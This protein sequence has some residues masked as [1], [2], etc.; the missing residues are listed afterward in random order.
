MIRKLR[1][2]QFKDIAWIGLFLAVMCGFMFW[3]MGPGLVDLILG[4]KPLTAEDRLEDLEGTYVSWEA[5]CPLEEYMETTKTTKVNGVSTGTKKHRSSWVVFDENRGICIS[6]EVPAKREDEMMLR[7]DQFYKAMEE[8]E[9]LPMGGVPV[10]GTLEKLE[11]EELRYFEYAMREMG[12][13]EET[14]VYQIRDGVVHG[15]PK[16]NIYGISAISGFLLLI[17]LFI[18]FKTFKNSAGKLIK[19]YLAAH[20]EVSMEQLESDFEAAKAMHGVW[21]GRNWTF[22]AKLEK[23]LLDNRQAIWVHTGSVRQGRGVNFYVW[24]EMLDGSQ[25]QVS[26]SSEKKCTEIM[27]S[28]GSF[29]H[30][31]VGNNPEYGYLLRNDREAFLGMKYRGS[32]EG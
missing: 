8:G 30:M 28:Y 12:F 10:A 19:E 27:E 4:D 16:S 23:M 26:L 29:Q 18:L 5:A 13:P 11:G 25:C 15:E 9:N 32:M 17:L 2:G 7:A 24:W 6:V 3:K 14:V 1:M 31:A 20:P 22:S 21:V